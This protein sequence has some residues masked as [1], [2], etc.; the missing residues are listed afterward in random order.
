MGCARTH[1]RPTTGWIRAK[2]QQQK[3]RRR[4]T[5]IWFGASEC[6]AALHLFL[7]P[8]IIFT[9]RRSHP[10]RATVSISGEML[11]ICI[12]AHQPLKRAPT[13][14][15]QEIDARQPRI[16]KILAHPITPTR[17][18]GLTASPFR[19]SIRSTSTKPLQTEHER[20]RK[21]KKKKLFEKLILFARSVN[22]SCATQLKIFVI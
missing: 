4:A 10:S 18:C 9:F 13:R 20:K 3:R 2:I 8:K 22:T 16:G 14:G 12:A 11:N 19:R 15:A 1:Q 17:A 7:K 21:K 5:A 6:A